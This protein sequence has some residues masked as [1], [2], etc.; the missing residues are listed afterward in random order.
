MI[1]SYGEEFHLLIRHC[2]TK[3]FICFEYAP[4][5]FSESYYGFGLWDKKNRNCQ[6]IFW[7]GFTWF[8]CVLFP[9]SVGILSSVTFW[10]ESYS[11]LL[12]CVI[13][14]F[15]LFSTELAHISKR[16]AESKSDIIPCNRHGGRATDFLIAALC[17]FGIIQTSEHRTLNSTNVDIGAVLSGFQQWKENSVN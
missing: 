2:L 12:I 4:F 3:F 5:S 17:I 8:Y 6:S 11:I 14:W 13:D 16:D 10:W 9:P 7:C 1:I 15:F